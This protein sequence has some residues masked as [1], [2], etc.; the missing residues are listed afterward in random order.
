MKF[1]CIDSDGSR[2]MAEET[3]ILVEMARFMYRERTERARSKVPNFSGIL[4]TQF[5]MVF[6][7]DIQGIEFC[8]DYV[9]DGRKKWV[10]FIVQECALREKVP[11]NLGLAGFMGMVAE[12]GP[13]IP[14]PS[15]N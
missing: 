9:Y 3:T 2:I 11:D 14:H 13:K 12:K 1:F 4:E 6:L 5:K 10:K 8:G 7:G 15:L